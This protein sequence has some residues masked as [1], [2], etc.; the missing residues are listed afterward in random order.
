VLA[1]LVL[2]LTLVSGCTKPRLDTSD[3]ERFAVSVAAVREKLPMDAR[4]EFDAALASLAAADQEATSVS[5]RRSADA[6]RRALFEALSPS[7]RT[8]LQ[9]RSG[10]EVIAIATELR[11]Q[12]EAQRLRAQALERER[13]RRALLSEWRA[14][15]TQ[16]DAFDLETLAGLSVVEARL[17]MPEAEDPL[18]PVKDWF[19]IDAPAEHQTPDTP[20][21]EIELRLESQVRDGIY[22]VLLQIELFKIGET[23]PWRRLQTR[24]RFSRG[25]FFGDTATRRLSPEGLAELFNR[26]AGEPT[27]DPDELILVVRPVQLFNAS[28]QAFAGA[29]I[30]DAELARVQQL[31]DELRDAEAGS[32]PT[33]GA[34]PARA[35]PPAQPADVA[36]AEQA[37][38]IRAWRAKRLAQAYRD[39]AAA[40]RAERQAAEAAHAPFQR[41]LVKQA[42]FHWSESRIHRKP[43]IELEVYN[44]TPETISSCHCRGRLTSPERDRPWVDARF[45][46]RFRSGLAPGET[47]QV[48]IVPNWLGPWGGAPKDRADLVLEVEPTQ[49]DGKG[50]QDLFAYNFPAQREALLARLEALIDERG[51]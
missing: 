17:I 20:P 12:R 36:L 30:S 40:I 7:L 9:G 49:L 46:E 26:R 14:L 25:L 37:E 3:A 43:V 16:L 42:H 2:A 11:E 8:R 28:G 33:A 47:A 10:R 34:G 18:D 4:A 44:G 13:R 5:E 15:R 21:A 32:A 31:L 27:P 51:W 19:A 48:R 29:P 45:V 24:Q 41:F 6:R 50:Q 35:S 22:A 1:L 39:K 38:A 23:E